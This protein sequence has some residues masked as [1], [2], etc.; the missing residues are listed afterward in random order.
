MGEIIAAD[1]AWIMV[2]TAMVMLMTSGLALFYGGMVRR[3]NIISMLSLCFVTMAIISVQWVF[4]GYSMAFGSDIGGFVGN[5]DYLLLNGVGQEASEL[6]SNLPHMV[7]SAFQMMFAIITTAIIASAFAERVKFISWIL[8]IVL[9]ST[10]V[11][12]P[13]A[14][15]V[16][17]G[18]I[19]W[20]PGST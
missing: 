10:I 6:A 16:W 20:E 13:I 3:K 2:C 17:G 12:A 9:W 1:T 7:F 11:Y 18:R 8:F 5:M 19:Y 15:W 14:H 4:F